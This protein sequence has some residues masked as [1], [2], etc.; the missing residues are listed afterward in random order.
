VARYRPTELK[1]LLKKL[2]T[3]PKKGLSQNFLIDGNIIRKIVEGVAPG[4][5]VLEIGPG[6]GA[7]T[8]ALLEAGAEVIAVERDPLFAEELK[9]LQ[10]VR[11][12]CEDIL[13]FDLEKIRPPA[14]V[15]ANL[16]YHLTSPILGRLLPRRDLFRS[17][18]VMVQEEVARRICAAP[19]S[20]AYSALSLFIRFYGEPS[21][22]FKV[23]RRCFYP[24]PKVDSAVVAI[25]LKKPPDIEEN[26][27]F[28]VMRA[29]FSQRRKTLKSSLKQLIPQ[30]MLLEAL[31]KM[32]KPATTRPEELSCGEFVVLAGLLF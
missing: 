8:E 15:V 12:F 14:R 10:G 11:L 21:Y 1:K 20:A 9:S 28:T 22:R 27:F 25:T 31:E 7:L 18:T 13:K 30:E 32:G 16:P 3:G 23:G 29:A 17:L 6:P 2:E 19:G 24:T 26:K 4:E 5:R